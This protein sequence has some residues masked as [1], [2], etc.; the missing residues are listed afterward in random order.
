MSLKSGVLMSLFSGVSFTDLQ[1]AASRRDTARKAGSPSAAD[2]AY[3]TRFAGPSQVSALPGQAPG[4]ADDG[5]ETDL[6]GVR[7]AA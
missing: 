1:R 5:L 7:D 2:V 3:A 4:Q 6:A